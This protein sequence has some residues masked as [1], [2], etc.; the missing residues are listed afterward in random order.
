[1]LS[2]VDQCAFVVFDVGAQLRATRDQTPSLG[3]D[4]GIVQHDGVLGLARDPAQGFARLVLVAVP[5][6]VA[7]PLD[8][9]LRAVKRGK[10]RLNGTQAAPGL[11]DMLH[12]H[13]KVKP[14]QDALSRPAR[15]RAHQ[16]WQGGVAV[17][18]HGHRVALPPAL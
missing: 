2:V 9:D 10:G 12:A 13:G 16:R 5:K 3:F 15:G 4:A 1:M 11:L 17:A 8:I 18:D 6:Q 14:V 7:Q